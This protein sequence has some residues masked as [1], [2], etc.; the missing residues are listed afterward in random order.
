MFLLI[1]PSFCVLSGNL[2]LRK[3]LKVQLVQ[4]SLLEEAGSIQHHIAT[5]VI[6]GEGDA[7]ADTGVL[8]T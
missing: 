5:T 1:Q 7:V 8:H 3:N 2:F 4:L 6:L